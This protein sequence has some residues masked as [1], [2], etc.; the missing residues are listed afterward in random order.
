VIWRL[1]TEIV[2]WVE[3]V[4]ARQRPVITFPRQPKHSPALKIPVPSIEN[5]PLK[6][7][8]NNAGTLG[9]GRF[10]AVRAEATQRR[11]TGPTDKNPLGGG[12]KNIHRSPASRRRRRK[13]EPSAWG[14]T[15]P[16]CSGTWPSRLEESRIWNSKMWSWA[17][18]GSDLRM[19]LLTR[20]SSNCRRQTHPL[21][22]ECVT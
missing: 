16:L 22:K 4:I 17:P 8:L 15:G 20:T 14:I 19:I 7:S 10:Y 11:S 1:K 2:E 6:M 3:T 5:S 9:S 13:M 21:V 18:R 12:F